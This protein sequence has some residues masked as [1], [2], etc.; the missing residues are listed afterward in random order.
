MNLKIT[1]GKKPFGSYKVVSKRAL[2]QDVV[3]IVEFPNCSFKW[4]PTYQQLIDIKKSLD[5]V[6]VLNDNNKNS[7]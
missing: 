5:K 6:E 4:M 1:I 2:I 3:V 7:N